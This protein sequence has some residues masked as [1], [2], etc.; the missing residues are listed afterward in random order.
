MVC[1][2]LLDI[3]QDLICE[4]RRRVRRGGYDEHTFNHRYRSLVFEIPVWNHT[5]RPSASNAGSRRL[6]L[7]RPSDV[8]NA[9]SDLADSDMD[10]VERAQQME[11][12]VVHVR[13]HGHQDALRL[14]IATPLVGALR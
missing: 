11:P 12:A 4:T 7:S 5:A 14:A 6:G 2:Q 10:M 8:I 3:N 1:R 13:V 9:I